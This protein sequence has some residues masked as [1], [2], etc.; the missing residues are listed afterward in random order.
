MAGG[1][2]DD[3]GDFWAYGG[4]GVTGYAGA[5]NEHFQNLVDFH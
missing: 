2:A 4:S 1:V 5:V 3:G